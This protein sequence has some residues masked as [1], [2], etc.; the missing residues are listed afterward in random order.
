MTIT[1]TNATSVL[2]SW[3]AP[4]TPV[5]GYEVFYETAA[6]ERHSVGNTTDTNLTLSGLDIQIWFIFVVAYGEEY[7]LPSV[8]STIALSMFK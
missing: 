6:G 4:T 1:N 7:M 5:A 3:T 2:V 8:K